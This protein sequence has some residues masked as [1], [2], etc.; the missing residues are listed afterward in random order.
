VSYRFEEPKRGE[1]IVFR[2]PRD[3]SKY[4]IK[5]VIALPGDTIEIKNNEVTIYNEKF[6]DGMKLTEPYIK[7]WS[8][9]SPYI[10]EKLKENEYFVMGDNRDNSSDS[11]VWGV[12]N[13]NRITG[14]VFLRLFP[15]SKVDYLPGKNN[16]ESK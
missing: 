12:L 7:S 15:F 3:P 1:V 6:S 9:N 11:R 10:K 8:K 14:R 2:Y 4:F 16:Y 13:R 5:R